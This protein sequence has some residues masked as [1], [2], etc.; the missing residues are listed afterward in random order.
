MIDWAG[1]QQRFSLFALEKKPYEFMQYTG[2]KDKNGREIYAGDIV[3]WPSNLVG[4][5]ER[6]IKDLGVIE[7]DSRNLGYWLKR[8]NGGDGFTGTVNLWQ[9]AVMVGE[10]IGNIYEN[11]ELL[12]RAA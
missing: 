11:P 2:L 12:E 9:G 8:V 1:C 5:R 10:V 4:R 6:R 7:Y 3:Q